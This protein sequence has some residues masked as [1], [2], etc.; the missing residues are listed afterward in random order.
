MILHTPDEARALVR[1]HIEQL[2]LT[3]EAY[4][5]RCGAH[6]STI[7]EWLLN[8]RGRGMP[9]AV[10]RDLGLRMVVCYE[11]DVPPPLP[12]VQPAQAR[13]GYDLVAMAG[14]RGTA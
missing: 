14:P 5:I 1:A 13:T 3:C 9:K 7:S 10:Q 8:R 12:A 11:A 2:G 4:A 6:S